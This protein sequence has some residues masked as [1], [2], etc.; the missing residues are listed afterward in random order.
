MGE[1]PK[2]KPGHVNIEIYNSDQVLRNKQTPWELYK[3]T[4]KEEE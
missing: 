1:N 3:E 4:D 2:Y